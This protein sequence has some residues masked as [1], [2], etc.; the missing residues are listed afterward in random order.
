MAKL[1]AV[2]LRE[3]EL[4]G[5]LSR[6]SAFLCPSLARVDDIVAMSAHSIPHNGSIQILV[7]DDDRYIREFLTFLLE[8]EGY[9]V[10]QA[11]DGAAA[12]QMASAEPPSLVISDIAMP[13][14]SGY[15]LM[16]AMRHRATLRAIPVILMT[17]MIAPRP[18]DVPVLRKPFDLDI[19]LETVETS[20]AARL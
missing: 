18:A 15:E 7:V 16:Y 3:D 14:T 10:V 6:D 11:A 17:A 2:W 5:S 19:L 13:A 20:L 12:L 1:V 9:G 8:D 4:F